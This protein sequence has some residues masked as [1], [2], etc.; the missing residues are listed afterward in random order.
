MK[1]I[2]KKPKEKLEELRQIDKSFLFFLLVRKILLDGLHKYFRLEIEGLENIPKHGP[3]LITPNHSGFAGFDAAILA[4]EINGN[5]HRIPRVLTHHFWFISKFTAKNAKKLGFI[6]ANMKN[7]VEH[8]KKNNL[9]VIF[10]EGEKGN[11]KPTS[12]RYHLEEFK[13]GF[14]RMA[15]EAQCPIIPT[16][17]IGAEETH[18]NLKRL[19]IF[20]K[21]MIPIPLNFLP[22]PAKWKIIFLPAIKLPYKRSALDD[23]ELIVELAQEVREAMQKALSAELEKRTSIYF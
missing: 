12:K 22:L 8:L 6:E 18:I 17:I 23:D 9:V 14:I 21:V 7:G 4:H 2:F 20:E 5:C 11:F 19:K 15:I 1:N 16:L 10:P 13:R 3:S